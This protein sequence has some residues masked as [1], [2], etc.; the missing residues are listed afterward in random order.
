MP[1]KIRNVGITS[2]DLAKIEE[3]YDPSGESQH[4]RHVA[5][6]HEPTRS[7]MAVGPTDRELSSYSHADVLI[8]RHLGELEKIERK[9]ANESDP[10]RAGK[11][12]KQQEIKIRFI[13]RLRTEQRTQAES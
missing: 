8:H 2:A 13:E 1:R 4:S 11:L 12:A 6:G 10:I 5:R 9:L 7:D 3:G